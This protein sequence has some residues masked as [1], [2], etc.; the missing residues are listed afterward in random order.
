VLIGTVEV[1][2]THSAGA[3]W[4]SEANPNV[5]FYDGER[6]PVI[7]SIEPVVAGETHALAYIDAGYGVAVVMDHKRHSP[8]ALWALAGRIVPVIDGDAHDARFLD[9]SGVIVALAAKGRAKRDTSG[10]VRPAGKGA[11]S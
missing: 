9:P 6:T 11:Q 3:R 8:P 1:A 10:F 7:N 2:V 4:S 5:T